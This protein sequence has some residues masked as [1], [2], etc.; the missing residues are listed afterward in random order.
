MIYKSLI[1]FRSKKMIFFCRCKLWCD[2]SS[3]LLF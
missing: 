3:H 2:C 1:F